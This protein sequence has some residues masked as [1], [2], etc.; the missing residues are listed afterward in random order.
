MDINSF[1]KQIEA[2]S[3]PDLSSMDDH[4]RNMQKVLIKEDLSLGHRG[5]IVNPAVIYLTVA[6]LIGLCFLINIIWA[7]N[8]ITKDR[9]EPVHQEP[10]LNN[11]EFPAK[12]KHTIP[13]TKDSLA[14]TGAGYQ[15]NKKNASSES[16]GEQRNSKPVKHIPSQGKDSI[17]NKSR[18]RLE[19]PVKDAGSP[20]PVRRSRQ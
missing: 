11:N 13:G 15:E 2:E 8:G 18:K 4:W 6:G 16:P 10:V 19:L 14:A 5:T 9:T 1:F 7:P 20:P 17:A 12:E 3:T